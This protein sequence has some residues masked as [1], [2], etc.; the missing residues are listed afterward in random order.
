MVLSLTE[1]S[2]QELWTCYCTPQDG[3]LIQYLRSKRHVPAC[4]PASTYLP[5][6]NSSASAWQTTSVETQDRTCCQLTSCVSRTRCSWQMDSFALNATNSWK[7]MR[8]TLSRLTCG[9]PL[10]KLSC[11]HLLHQHSRV[12]HYSGLEPAL[13]KVHRRTPTLSEAMSYS[14]TVKIHIFNYDL[15]TH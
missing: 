11:V 3:F 7:R 8:A 12:R 13:A 14:V 2:K 9:C 4:R 15:C 1:I 5:L 6:N 10:Q